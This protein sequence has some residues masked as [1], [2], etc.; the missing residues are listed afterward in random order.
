MVEME[1]AMENLATAQFRD[2]I[3]NSSDGVWVSD[4]AHRIVYANAAM[5][6]IA[7]IA[8]DRIVGT[9]LLCEPTA[10]GY[11]FFRSHYR[12]AVDTG[13]PTRYECPATTPSGQEMWQGG[14][15]TPM[16]ENGEFSGMVCTV[17]DIT[18][19]KRMEAEVVAMR[20]QLQAT[21]DAIPDLLFEVD[22]GGHIHRYH[23]PRTDSSPRLSEVLLGKAIA[24]LI[25]EDPCMSALREAQQTGVSIG[26]QLELMLP[27]GTCSFELSVTRK[28]D[29]PGEEQ[30]FIILA[31]DITERKAAEARARRLTQFYAALGECKRATLQ[32][33]SDDELF[34]SV[35]RIMVESGGL[36]LAWIGLIDAASHEVK[37]VA[38]FG[39]AEDYLSNIRITADP[40]DPDGQ[41]PTGKAVRENR[42]VWCQDFLHDARTA[43]WHDRAARC[44]LGSSASLPL[45]R[46]G[47]VIG[48]LNMYSGAANAFDEDLRQLSLEMVRD[49]GLALDNF[50]RE[51]E[52]LAADSHLRQLTSAVEQS[53]ESI[54]ITDLKANIEYVNEA[55]VRNTGYSR[56]EVIGRNPRI[57]HTGKTP[58]TIYDELWR[59]ITTGQSWK[60][61]LYN[62][63][64]DGS[65]YVEHTIITP[66]R[67]ADGRITHYV[68]VKEDV[69][70]K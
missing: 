66:I 55:F 57:L 70:E 14:W 7:E 37:T 9:S 56:D 41:G 52:R 8:V 5:A 53:S 12:A 47:A 44:G 3:E 11:A 2:I 38:S 51:A 16:M 24:G 35:C 34:R 49:I 19:R 39:A 60:G 18:E 69:T 15:L 42:P 28:P 27:Y 33:A 58:Q 23:S 40:T 62:R 21:M 64:K 48:A 67:Q 31:R 36:R 17:Q 10:G 68:A 32:C 20:S 30:R 43:S 50:D 45:R 61:D 65:E 4:K 6:R 29:T 26:K 1:T 46:R 13:K 54:V 63:R 59:T 22:L 25:R